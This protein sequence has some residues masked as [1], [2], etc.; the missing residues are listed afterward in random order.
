MR[1][2][3]GA[4]RP[5]DGVQHVVQLTDR[6]RLSL[7]INN[8]LN[9]DRVYPSGYSYL[10]VDNGAAYRS[11]WW[12]PFRSWAASLARCTAP[13]CWRSAAGATSSGST[14]QSPWCWP[15]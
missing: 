13:W 11:V 2:R 15:W 8:V 12:A 4:Q 14:S 5:A 3:V 1:L 7:Q 9:N 6:V 10:Y